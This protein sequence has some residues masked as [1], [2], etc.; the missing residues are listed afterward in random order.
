M[1]HTVKIRHSPTHELYIYAERCG[2]LSVPSVPWIFILTLHVNPHFHV[3]FNKTCLPHSQPGVTVS[4]GS[5]ETSPL[6]LS[7]PGPLHDPEL[8]SH[9]A[10]STL[11]NQGG[12]NRS[13][14]TDNIYP[15]EPDSP[16]HQQSQTKGRAVAFS[17]NKARQRG[18][19]SSIDS[20][21]TTTGTTTQCYEEP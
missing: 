21:T 16:Q 15:T 14:D 3:P 18:S 20:I 2:L 10:A 7:P 1:W 17:H 8:F 13:G 5:L 6:S 19:H 9:R 11:I 12:N 4:L